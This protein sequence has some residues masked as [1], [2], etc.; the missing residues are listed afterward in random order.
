MN[1]LKPITFPNVQASSSLNNENVSIASQNNNNHP[2]SLIKKEFIK[3][4]SFSSAEVNSKKYQV[5]NGISN[6]LEDTQNNESNNIFKNLLFKIYENIDIFKYCFDI[7][8]NEGVAVLFD[9]MSSSVYG[10]LIQNG[11]YFCS[12]KVFNHL[13]KSIKFQMSNQILN[14]MLVNLLSAILTAFI[15]NP[16]WVL[17]IRMAKRSKEVL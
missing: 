15:T 13:L 3:K 16:I 7:I 11:V 10:A 12:V 6:N 5:E 8:K 4:N 14:S 9:G 2:S 17:N 1:S